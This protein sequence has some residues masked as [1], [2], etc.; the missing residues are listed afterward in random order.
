[1]DFP[2]SIAAVWLVGLL[3]TILV[4][5]I[6]NAIWDWVKENITFSSSKWPRLKGHWDIEHTDGSRLGEWA[7]IRQQFGPKFRG[8]LHT[9]DP[10]AKGRMFVQEIRGELQDRYHAL[11]TVQQKE[12]HFTEMGAGMITLD[13]NQ[14]AAS[15]K[16]VF[17]G[18]SAPE[19]GMSIFRMKKN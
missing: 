12:D 19:E 18:A 5:V 4:G 15:G 11:F 16:S 9:P 17:F 7:H 8:E 2:L 3:G 13:A 1:M 14:K 10:N 6:T